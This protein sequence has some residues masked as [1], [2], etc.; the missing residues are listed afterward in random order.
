MIV[1]V[2]GESDKTALET[3]ARCL[4]RDLAAERVRVEAIGGAHALREYL[5]RLGDRSALRLAGMVDLG[6]AP[7]VARALGIDV[8]ALEEAGFFVCTT[9]LEDE[10]I[11]AIGPH[12]VETVIREQ[13]ELS[14]FRSFQKQPFHRG[15]PLSAQLHR[16]MGTHSGRKA[17]YARA[18]V[19]A[20]APDRVPHPLS[21]LLEHIA[22]HY[23]SN[24]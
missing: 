15:R 21:G 18:L 23:D 2:E 14:A 10:L 19:E 5:R 4:G 24:K 17:A 13:G 1:V 22:S 8:A 6:E 7:A 3:L 12:A 11:R 9:N 16:F 20:G